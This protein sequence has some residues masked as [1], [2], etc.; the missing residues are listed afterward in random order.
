MELARCCHFTPDSISPDQAVFHSEF[1]LGDIGRGWMLK[2]L[3][4]RL[5]DNSG[6]GIMTMVV[7]ALLSIV[8]L[9]M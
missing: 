9:A 6:K 8:C 7:G 5:T 2:R 1:R 4:I 3:K